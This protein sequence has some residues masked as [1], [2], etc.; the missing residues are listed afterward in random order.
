MSINTSQSF[1]YQVPGTRYQVPGLLIDFNI[2]PWDS[3]IF[4]NPVAQI[5]QIKV[6]DAAEASDP[7][8]EF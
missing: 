4:G 3:E 7:Y 2:V 5:N 6:G 1:R 8:C